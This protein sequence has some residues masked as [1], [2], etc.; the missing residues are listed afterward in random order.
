MHVEYKINLPDHDWVVAA[1]H[2]LIPSVYAGI[3]IHRNGLGN[4]DAVG[5][6]GPTFIAIRS[7]KH[8]AFTPLSHGFD[9]EKL[10][11]L[12]EFDTITRTGIYKLV[13]PILVFTVDGGPDENGI[14]KSLRLQ[15][16]IS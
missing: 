13:K 9:F 4:R 16:T 12:T 15:S 8:S 7:G 14:K 10:L 6:S 2:K 1:R 3:E 11:C 5:F